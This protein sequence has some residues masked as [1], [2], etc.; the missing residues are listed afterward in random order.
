MYSM[1]TMESVQGFFCCS[2]KTV[3]EVKKVDKVLRG[4]R[5]GAA[6]R[7][8]GCA[9]MVGV[10]Q[11]SNTKG[12]FCEAKITVV[13]KFCYFLHFSSQYAKVGSYPPFASRFP[14]TKSC[15]VVFFLHMKIAHLSVSFSRMLKLKHFVEGCKQRAN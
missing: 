11:R 7:V 12:C 5:H 3:S 1:Y 9:R 6:I 15:Q 8:V 10:L 4:E 2:E 13:L 14:T